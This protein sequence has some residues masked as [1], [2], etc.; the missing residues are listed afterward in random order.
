MSTKQRGSGWSIRLALWFYGC[1]GYMPFF[2]LLY[3]I[4]FIYY[5]KASNVRRALKLYYKKI[6]IKYTQRRYFEHLRKFAIVMTDRFVTKCDSSKYTLIVENKESI[7]KEIRKGGVILF[8][9]FGGWSVTP[10]FFKESDLRINIIMQEAIKEDIKV[11]EKKLIKTREN[12][13]VLD[14]A[15]TSKLDA[16]IKIAEALLDK[17]IISM[18]GD[19]ANNPK[20]AIMVD[21]FGSPAEFNKTP[22]EIALKAEVPIMA[23]FIIYVKP[24]VYKL[25]C[26]RLNQSKDIEKTV[27]EYVQAYENVIC[28]YPNQWF[29]LYDFWKDEELK[30]PS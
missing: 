18:M 20:H 26:A 23:F 21:F 2:I 11:V 3:P 7:V 27:K 8:S 29:N 6:G 4:T 12:I 5:F 13:R 16:S 22:F 30:K 28:R 9:H 24:C 10:S 25:E 1:F 19:R 14:L 17:E 15:H